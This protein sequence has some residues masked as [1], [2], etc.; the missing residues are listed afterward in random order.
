MNEADRMKAKILGLLAVGL[1]AGPMAAVAVPLTWTLNGTFIGGGTASGSFVYDADGAGFLGIALTT[2]S[3]RTYTQF[4]GAGTQGLVFLQSGVTAGVSTIALNLQG[5]SLSLLT[6]SGGILQVNPIGGFA[7]FAE[8][9]C[10][11]GTGCRGG[12]GSGITN[13]EPGASTLTSIAASVPEPGTL[14]L[15]G[16]GLVGLSVSSRRKAA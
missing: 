13:W 7:G 3:G 5:I 4:Q 12:A 8:F 9:R 2:S 6:N 15:L 1:L 14:A 11:S 16:L 10:L